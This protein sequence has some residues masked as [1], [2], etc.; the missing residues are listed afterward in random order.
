MMQPW[1]KQGKL[2]EAF[3][4]FKQPFSRLFI[5]LSNHSKV[6]RLQLRNLGSKPEFVVTVSAIW[7]MASCFPLWFWVSPSAGWK[8]VTRSSLCF[9]LA[10]IVC[11]S[12][13]LSSG[14]KSEF[15]SCIPE[16]PFVTWTPLFFAF[17]MSPKKR[18]FLQ[19]SWGCAPMSS[20]NN[21]SPDWQ[22]QG[23]I[24]S[25]RKRPSHYRNPIIRAVNTS[26]HSGALAESMFNQALS[27]FIQVPIVKCV[28]PFR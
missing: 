27:L 26:I 16:A 18:S 5:S 22:A 15:Q 10:L 3:S 8:L 17:G 24:Q 13:L 4:L 28:W 11:D 25:R 2:K 9:S 20:L 12:R 7:F 21:R 6:H 19:T 1:Y 23:N 14:G